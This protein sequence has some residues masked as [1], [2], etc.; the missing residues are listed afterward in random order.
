MRKPLPH[1]EES[2]GEIA[3]PRGEYGQVVVLRHHGIGEREA[4]ILAAAGSHGVALELTEA[5]RRLAGVDDAGTGVG[6]LGDVQGR[7]GGDSGHPLHEVESDALGLQ[8]RPRGTRNLGDHGASVELLAVGEE[9]RDRDRLA[10]EEHGG[11][12]D[13]SP[14]EHP[15]LTGDEPGRRDGLGRDEVLRGDV[16]P[17]G[18]FSEGCADD[19]EDVMVGQ[20][21]TATFL[22][23]ASSAHSR[24]R[25]NGGRVM[26]KSD[27]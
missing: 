5:W 2:L 26:G 1:L 17:R 16:P 8:H 21:G 15:G 11:G 9:D 23:G 25:A 14:A 20:H 27:R 4:M 22:A 19:G 13:L 24:W 10:G 3:A 12:E 18:V 7:E 6:H